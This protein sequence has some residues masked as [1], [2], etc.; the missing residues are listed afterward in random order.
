MAQ[1]SFSINLHFLKHLR[2]KSG[3]TIE[4]IAEAVDAETEGD[5]ELSTRQYQRIEKYG[6]TTKK[7]AAAL[8]KVFGTSVNELEGG[9]SSDKSPWYVKS[10]DDLYGKLT[11]GHHEVIKEVSLEVNV[12]GGAL[13]ENGDVALEIIDN[14]L[15]I[16]LK[17]IHHPDTDKTYTI[18]WAIRPAII[19]ESG[20]LWASLSRWQQLDWKQSMN[21]LLY[22]FTNKVIINGKSLVPLSSKVGFLISFDDFVNDRSHG[23]SSE[24][25]DPRPFKMLTDK[26]PKNSERSEIVFDM[27]FPHGEWINEGSQFFPKDVDF[28]CSLTDWMEQNRSIHPFTI[29]PSMCPPGSLIIATGKSK[30]LTIT[31]AWQDES[32]Q[33]HQAPWPERQREKLAD[34]L[35][36][37]FKKPSPLPIAIGELGPEHFPPLAPVRETEVSGNH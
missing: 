26:I 7:T 30:R 12:G 22:N 15:P 10:R 31:R 32:G 37:F 4:A 1:E 18:E 21:N 3:L 17:V 11:L 23:K 34:A 6:R 2:E 29:H 16:E 9:Q 27:P 19:N 25:F 20:I 5:S 24:K 33:A 35:E 14:K 8:A 36:S 28:R 13:N